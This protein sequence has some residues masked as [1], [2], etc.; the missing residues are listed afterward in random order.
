MS[1]Q[2]YENN[3]MT[4]NNVNGEY[5]IDYT[6]GEAELGVFHLIIDHENE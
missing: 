6:E 5:V 1:D 2:I 4:V 3:H